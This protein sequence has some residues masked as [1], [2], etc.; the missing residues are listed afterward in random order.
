MA[1]KIKFRKGKYFVHQVASGE[2]RDFVS[3]GTF[4]NNTV[5]DDVVGSSVMLKEEH[6]EANR[7]EEGQGKV[8]DDGPH[9]CTATEFN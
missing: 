6:G 3:R 9:K 1:L 4:H 8:L 7:K 5:G 2:G